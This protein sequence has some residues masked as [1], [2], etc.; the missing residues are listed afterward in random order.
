MSHTARVCFGAACPPPEEGQTV[1]TEPLTNRLSFAPEDDSA[2]EE[3]HIEDSSQVH[4]AEAQK[5]LSSRVRPAITPQGRGAGTRLTASPYAP[6]STQQ[7]L[8]DPA[9]LANSPFQRASHSVRFSEDT[10]IHVIEP[11]GGGTT[12][13]EPRNVP[14]CNRPAT[15]IRKPAGQATR[16]GQGGYR[17][18]EALGW[19]ERKYKETQSH[20]SCPED[21]IHELAQQYLNTRLCLSKQDPDCVATVCAEVRKHMPDAPSYEG[22]WHV[23]DFLT[24]YLRNTSFQYRRSLK[25]KGGPRSLMVLQIHRVSCLFMILV[26]SY[27][28]IKAIPIYLHGSRWGLEVQRIPLPRA[29]HD[30]FS[31]FRRKVGNTESNG[32]EDEP[33]SIVDHPGDDVLVANS[34]ECNGGRGGIMGD[35]G[36]DHVCKHSELQLRAAVEAELR[37]QGDGIRHMMSPRARE[38]RVEDEK[39]DKGR[40]GTHV[41]RDMERFKRNIGQQAFDRI[42]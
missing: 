1:R 26:P 32:A 12:A 23:K 36:P 10:L 30:Y 2:S 34:S 6:D 22:D 16:V 3:T 18:V 29:G 31:A 37:Q 40:L 15:V 19:S 38:C 9:S 14:R 8:E 25:K 20:P 7:R 5:G 24:T 39:W 33:G 17:L 21:L 35:F 28:T 4:R 41:P 13:H 42:G 27:Y 11:Q